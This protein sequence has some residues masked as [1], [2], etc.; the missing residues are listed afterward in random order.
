[1]QKKIL[2]IATRKSP[3]ALWQ[4]NHIAHQIK[5]QWPMYTT[6]LVPLVTTGD[7]FLNHA[8]Q[9]IGGKGLF[10]KELEDALLKN[11]ADIAVHSM[12]DVPSTLPPGLVI[13]TICKRDNPFD[14]LLCN[15]SYSLKTLPQHARI[16]TTSLRRRAQLLAYRSDLHPEVLRGNIHTRIEKLQQGLYDA[17]ILARAS[18]ERMQMHHLISDTLEPPIMYPACGQ[19]A[20]GIETRADDKEILDLLLPLHDPITSTCLQAERHVNLLLGGNC[21]TPIAIF[22]QFSPQTARLS[23][24]T[25]IMSPDGKVTIEDRQ[26][27]LPEHSILLA[28]KCVSSLYAQGAKQL[29]D[30]SS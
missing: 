7:K 29:L 27:G 25:R 13:S 4:A 24:F 30:E 12:K 21:H 5:N 22:C 14:V 8:L 10:V 9:E 15:G 1:M 18:L 2:R 28:E 11:K 20:L 6:E 23:L 16:G 3:L 19:G 17:I 26:Q